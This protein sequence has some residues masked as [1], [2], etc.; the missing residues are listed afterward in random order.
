MMVDQQARAEQRVNVTQVCQLLNLGLAEN[1]LPGIQQI[2]D[3]WCVQ[4]KVTNFDDLVQKTTTE[5][6]LYQSLIDSIMVAETYF[7]RHSGHFDFVRQHILPSFSGYNRPLRILS[8]GCATGE[9]PYSLAM[10]LA[11][12]IPNIPHRIF[13]CDISEANIRAAKLGVYK[14]W[15]LREPQFWQQ[16][17]RYL[18]TLDNKSYQVIPALKNAVTFFSCNLTADLSQQPMLDSQSFDL[19]FCRNLLIYLT[20]EEA[21]KLSERLISLL[22]PQGW[23]IPGPSD[24]INVYLSQLSAMESSNGLVF[25]HLSPNTFRQRQLTAL[26][27]INTEFS[28]KK[29]LE[30]KPVCKARPAVQQNVAVRSSA[31]ND[32]IKSAS[33]RPATLEQ[34]INT[35]LQ[36]GNA[37]SALNLIQ[38]QLLSTPLC[39]EAYLLQALTY[40]QMGRYVSALASLDKA[41]Y[42]AP[43]SPL[44]CYFSAKLLQ[45]QGHSV[46]ARQQL[47]RAQQ[48]LAR[49]DQLQ[50]LPLVQLGTVSEL[51]AA[52]TT[53][54][55][56]VNQHIDSEGSPQ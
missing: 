35:I 51:M 31:N 38:R 53:E 7:F 19:I 43:D 40:W 18:Q 10:L 49:L 46:Q 27:E 44:P 21:Q 30:R 34:Q 6:T 11:T 13:A 14:A 54:L 1:R 36:T 52:V 23:L 26:T 2:V 29:Q 45:K 15:S 37:D 5:P 20:D 17:Q 48:A 4:H 16:T 12:E 32:G 47:L 55:A 24:P 39:T 25:R 50:P 3:E 41:I 28:V 8:A 22:A 9:E 33:H 56:E 42:L